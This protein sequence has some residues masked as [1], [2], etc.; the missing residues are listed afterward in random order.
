MQTAARDLAGTSGASRSE[1]AALFALVGAFLAIVSYGA[2]AAVLEA[3]RLDDRRAFALTELRDPVATAGESAEAFSRFRSELDARSRFALVFGSAVDRDQRGFYHLFAG[4]FLYPA[5]AV[6]D[7]ARADAVMVFGSPPPS[8]LR[9]F[10]RLDLLDG[11]W[12][13]RRAA[14]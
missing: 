1:R 2:A 10:E 6:D 3:E 11:I 14:S 13:G 12:L 9:E 7:P 8:V 4:F 5:V